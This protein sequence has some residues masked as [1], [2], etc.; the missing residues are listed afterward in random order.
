LWVVR[1]KLGELL[2]WDGPDT[3]VGTR[4]PTLRDRMP[5]DL[6]DAPRGPDFAA[7]PLGAGR[8]LPLP[9]PTGGLREAQRIVG[10]G[11]HGR[12]QAVPPPP[13][14]PRD[15]PHNRTGVVQALGRAST[16]Q[17]ARLVGT[18]E[19]GNDR[20][21]LGRGRRAGGRSE[22]V[23]QIGPLPRSDLRTPERTRAAPGRGRDHSLT[24]YHVGVHHATPSLRATALSAIWPS[25]K[26]DPI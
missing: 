12:D 17:C 20:A 25:A 10:Q 3:G 18:A 8:Q 23:C 7:L 21:F 14:I 2:G 15:D 16:A 11:L 24:K 13:R 4:V 26:T 9:R 5:A 1:W 22:S 6:R 19:R